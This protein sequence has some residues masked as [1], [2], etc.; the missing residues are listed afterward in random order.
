MGYTHYWNQNTL[1]TD[2]P[3]GALKIIRK[4]LKRHAAIVQR[5]YDDKR[6]PVVRKDLICFNGIGDDGAETFYFDPNSSDGFDGFCK[7]YRR[8]YDL[9][10][11]EVL[12]VLK[13]FIPAMEL[14][15]DG[16]DHALI[17]KYRTGVHDENW[18]QAVENVREYYG[19]EIDLTEA[20]CEATS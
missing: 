1:G 16:F 15:S 20:G 18:P 13:H 5:E 8:P 14:S 4:I 6:R 9:P 3:S 10:V 7:T 19:I 11:C 2:I 17:E 12:L